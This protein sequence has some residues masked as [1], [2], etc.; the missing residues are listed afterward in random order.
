MCFLVQTQ[1]RRA[2]A[3]GDSLDGELNDM[4]LDAREE[5]AYT[6]TPRADKSCH[7]NL[8]TA[9]KP[10]FVLTKTQFFCLS[11][12]SPFFLKLLKFEGL[13]LCRGNKLVSNQSY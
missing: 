12:L 13:D 11:S 6:H 10:L 9:A 3:R 5:L 4:W 7:D 2:S 1:S 8:V